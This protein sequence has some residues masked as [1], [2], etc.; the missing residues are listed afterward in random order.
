MKTVLIVVCFLVIAA[1]I[2][3][4]ARL[5]VF[6]AV[7]RIAPSGVEVHVSDIPRVLVELR[8]ARNTPAFAALI[9]VPPDSTSADAISIQF[10]L[11]NGVPGLDWVLVEPRNVK[12]QSVFLNTSRAAGFS[13][14][15]SEINSVKYL[16]VEGGDL[17]SLCK[18]IITKSYR[19]NVDA[20]LVLIAH[21]FDWHS[22][23]V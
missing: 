11:E 2:A 10:S 21:G 23:G 16:R 1:G 22:E 14:K 3:W 9:F 6:S 19:V 7:A 8:S 5:P 17:A 13:P 15:L 12:E 20:S 18:S 4:V